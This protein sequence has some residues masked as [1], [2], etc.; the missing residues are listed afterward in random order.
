MNDSDGSDHDGV[1]LCESCSMHGS[2][3]TTAGSDQMIPEEEVTQCAND[4]SGKYRIN[5]DAGPPVAVWLCDR[6]RHLY[7]THIV[8]A[9][10]GT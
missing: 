3:A 7:D 5:P 1:C 4:A 2:P 6:H 9:L 8:E 10:A